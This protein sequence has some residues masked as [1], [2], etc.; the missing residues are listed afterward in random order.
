MIDWFF[1]LV[2]ITSCICSLSFQIL[3]LHVSSSFLHMTYL[4]KYFKNSIPFLPPLPWLLLRKM[5][6][7]NWTSANSRNA[8]FTHSLFSCKSLNSEFHSIPRYVDYR[9]KYQLT[10]TPHPSDSHEAWV[11][12][13]SA[14][15][16]CSMIKQHT[17]FRHI[18]H[19]SYFL[20]CFVLK[21]ISKSKSTGN[22]HWISVDYNHIT[23]LNILKFVVI[24]NRFKQIQCYLKIVIQ[25]NTSPPFLISCIISIQPQLQVTCAK[26][27]FTSECQRWRETFSGNELPPRSLPFLR[28]LIYKGSESRSYWRISIKTIFAETST[29]SSNVSMSYITRD[30]IISQRID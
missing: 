9:N 3:K 17:E 12:I 21:I 25:H 8:V 19:L 4:F 10:Y 5:I 11:L 15:M 16:I 27:R 1:H 29:W 30:F 18:R 24:K 20:P 26:R 7:L 2:F 22:F 6:L 14:V 28:L 23:L 13:V